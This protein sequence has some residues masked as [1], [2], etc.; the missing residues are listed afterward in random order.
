MNKV[1]SFA[2]LSFGIIAVLLFQA[3]VYFPIIVSVAI[4]IAVSLFMVNRYRKKQ[5]GV[6]ILLLW[7]VYALPFIHIPP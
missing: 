6:L 7:I 1:A 5:V 4:F 3:D 2:F